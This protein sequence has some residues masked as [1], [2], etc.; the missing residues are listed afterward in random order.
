MSFFMT[1][2]LVFAQLLLP[3]AASSTRTCR[4]IPGDSC[5]PDD[6]AWA[7]LNDTLHG[8]LIKSSPLASVCHDPHYDEE[9]CNALAKAWPLP[10]TLYPHASEI[11]APY[12]QNQSCDAFTPRSSP[13]RI[14]NYADYA[15][16]ISTA[17]HVSTALQFADKHNIRVVIKNTGHDYLG[18]STG[19]GSL[20]LWTHNMKNL[21]F[22]S[23]SSSGYT[24]PAVK[25]GAGVQ[26]FEAYTA[27][28]SHGLRVV[29]GECATVGVAGGYLQGGGHSILSST[30]GLAAD[31]ALE[32]EV[33]TA[34]GTCLVASPSEN[35]NL[36]WALSGGGG[37]TYGLVLSATV[38]AF[39]DGIV[40]GAILQFNNTGDTFWQGVQDFFAWVPDVVD[41][42]STVLWSVTNSSFVV[43]PITAPGKS[44]AQVEHLLEPLVSKM[45][46][47][48]I[49]LF[50][51]VTS[52]PTYLEHFDHYLGPLPYGLPMINF[53]DVSISGRLIPQR[54]L[55]N[56]SS[57]RDFIQTLKLSLPDSNYTIGGVVLNAA[58]SV[59]G[60]SAS[61]NAVLPAWR[62][63]N[64][65]VLSLA[66]WDFD[67]PLSS[68]L[69]RNDYINQVTVPAL[70]ALAPESGAYLNEGN[71][72]QKHWQ[73]E[74]YG[75]NYDRLRRIKHMYD[76]KDVF[77]ADTAVG[78]EAWTRDGHGRLCR[79]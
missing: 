79:P 77:F 50:T 71:I 59:A 62:D 51:S 55:R 37:G 70:T 60:N 61:S 15:V 27:A 3:L 11:M 68:N 28:A 32:Y 67:A 33:V 8:R 45:K 44:E 7:T 6:A 43:L 48:N 75:A 36:Y 4:C 65:H 42:G 21:D 35:S 41:S 34:N 23:Y 17:D 31:Q 78:S 73:K 63:T 9:A 49:S 56:T 12:W 1:I 38:K 53:A 29:G 14:G 18:K 19:K 74:F 40:G 58:H 72:A 76:P 16:N 30:Y 47:L 26:A 64:V 10:Q 22:I 66:H 39:K 20:S 52:F 54:V 69:A 25:M 46:K 2:W 5:W 57:N 13:C 24:G